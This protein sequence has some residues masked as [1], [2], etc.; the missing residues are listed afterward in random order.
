MREL[1]TVVS[2]AKLGWVIGNLLVLMA[3]SVC[4]GQERPKSYFWK[5]NP[6][7]VAPSS[8]PSVGTPP[9]FDV[10]DDGAFV[11]APL[12]DAIVPKPERSLAHVVTKPTFL[13]YLMDTVTIDESA[14]ARAMEPP[15]NPPEK[16]RYIGYS[17]PF[18]KGPCAMAKAVLA[19][20]PRFEIEWRNTEIPGG[21]DYEYP[22]IVD[23]PSKTYVSGEDL[24]SP[25]TFIA[26]INNARTAAGLASAMQPL[27]DIVVGSVPR[28]W[29]S[30]LACEES[31]PVQMLNTSETQE[32][33]DYSAFLPGKLRWRPI[34][35]R[36]GSA[37]AF[38]GN[39]PTVKVKQFL[40]M[41]WN[42]N[43]VYVPKSMDRVTLRMNWWKTISWVGK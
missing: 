1:F 15:E 40:S 29:I 42:V 35:E 17:P 33:R 23:D 19:E 43:A 39:K 21:G 26:A 4:S 36:D 12:I 22:A 3:H 8:S 24:K 9:E 34:T 28:N 10:E 37:I 11:P 38:I 20:D 7:A 25:E 6:V 41:S 5:D 31:S 16:L 2:C 18:C 32:F 27:E 13:A 14:L 30:F